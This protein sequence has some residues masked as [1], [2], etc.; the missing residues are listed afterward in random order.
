VIRFSEWVSA[1]SPSQYIEM[2]LVVF[3][4]VFV[5]VIGRELV[6]TRRRNYPT[7]SALPLA[8]DTSPSSPREEQQP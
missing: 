6:G 7:W 2:G 5:A 1:L 4:I 8:D 3:A